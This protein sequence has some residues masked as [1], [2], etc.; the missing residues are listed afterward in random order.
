VETKLTWGDAKAA[1]EAYTEK[2]LSWTLATITSQAENDFIVGLLQSST[3]K[4]WLGG[5]SMGASTGWSWVTGETWNYQ[6]WQPGEPG[7]DHG[8][9]PFFLGFS[10]NTTPSTWMWADLNDKGRY[11]IVESVPDGATTILLLG[12]AL[13]GLAAVARQRSTRRG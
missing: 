13:S 6:N 9:A 12:V 3:E 11:Y 8:T 7:Y 5:S 10:K 2:G 4:A 1:A